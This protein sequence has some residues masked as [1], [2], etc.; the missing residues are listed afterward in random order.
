[1]EQ[2]LRRTQL[3]RELTGGCLAAAVLVAL[4]LLV[5]IFTGW[6]SPILL[7][8]AL[9]VS[10]LVVAVARLRAARES[11]DLRTVISALER[12]HPELRHLLSA[13]AEQE[14]DPASGE[15]RY[16]QLRVVEEV[17]RHPGRALW[18]Q[19]L[20]AKLA[21]ARNRNIATVSALVILLV[22]LQYVSLRTHPASAS[23][24][25]EGITVT[26]GDTEIE[27]GTSLVISA[28]F[29]HDVP[30][31]ATL[32]LVSA[33]GKT[34]YIPLERQLADPVFGGSLSEVSEGGLYHIEYAGGKTRDYKISVFD[35]P[36]LV[37]A[38]AHLR[39]P[40]Y[41]H[42]TNRTIPDTLRVSAVEGTHLT[43]MLQLN[44]PVARARLVGR[45]KTLELQLTNN[46]VALLNEFLLTNSAR[47]SLALEDAQG[48]TNKFPS[49]FVL[50]AITNRR[51]D[52]K[53]VFPRGDQ[54]VSKLQEIQL[55]GEATGEFGLRNYGIGYTVG[56]KDPQLVALGE[57]AP[58][59]QKRSFIYLLAL[60]NL[61]V[62]PE[63]MVA[64]FAWADDFGAD[65]KPRR[66]F[67]DIFFA[68]VRPFDEIFRADQSGSSGDENGGQGGGEGNRGTQ[69]AQM[70][71]EIII[72]TWKLQQ[73]KSAAAN[74]QMP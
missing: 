45:D 38:E 37:R 52:L 35:Y 46:S 31:E 49:D 60:E 72:A 21:A 19:N 25:A 27:R 36:A 1:M 20:E 62:E 6:N 53:L 34:R 65:G 4:L 71:K 26:P 29:G 56:G 28:R 10:L 55:Q 70:Q 73:E 13:A 24:E 39:Y 17:L 3:H 8:V 7:L 2:V 47:Y 16:L 5:R 40:D 41:T 11:H 14:P 9:V 15:F 23:Q 22:A 30:A 74:T 18:E 54:R 63:D 58:G 50:V 12:D 66:T 43:Y 68:E 57:S 33:S 67:S 48:R 42:L 61:A 59:G 51:P 69:L 44:K 32:V 64:Y